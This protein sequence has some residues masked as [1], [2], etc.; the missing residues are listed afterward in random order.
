VE[1]DIAN[2]RQC[3][4]ICFVQRG[5]CLIEGG[6]EYY[7]GYDPVNFVPASSAEVPKWCPVIGK[8]KTGV[9]LKLVATPN[10]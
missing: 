9:T 4:Y 3:P 8:S 5:T 2:C 10:A 6:H 7:C 1:F